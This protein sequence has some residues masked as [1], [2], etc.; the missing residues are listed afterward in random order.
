MGD[1]GRGGDEAQAVRSLLDFRET[2][3]SVQVGRD[4]K[5]A[6]VHVVEETEYVSA[7]RLNP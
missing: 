3:A 1:N 2:V 7:T 6:H 4:A 5:Q